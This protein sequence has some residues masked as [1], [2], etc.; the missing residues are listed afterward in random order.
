MGRSSRI[1]SEPKTAG[2][3][4]EILS[5]IERIFTVAS[6]V[7]PVLSTELTSQI[8]HVWEASV[9]VSSTEKGINDLSSE[10]QSRLVRKGGN[11]LLEQLIQPGKINK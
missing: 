11:L 8:P 10:V 7:N 4:V 1:S 3:R 2:G 9:L 5:E 6:H